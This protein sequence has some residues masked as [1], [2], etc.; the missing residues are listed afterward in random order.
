MPVKFKRTFRIQDKLIVYE[1]KKIIAEM[2]ELSDPQILEDRMIF[3]L[4]KKVTS[5]SSIK[6]VEQLLCYSSVDKLEFNPQKPFRS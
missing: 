4:K 3:G 6:E 2:T 1:I 5:C